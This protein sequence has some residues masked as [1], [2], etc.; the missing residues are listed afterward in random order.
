M[1]GDKAYSSRA[2]RAHLPRR[3]IKAVVPDKADQAANQTKKGEGRASGF[4]RRRVVQEAQRR[5]AVH[6]QDQGLEAAGHAFRHRPDSYM[7]ELELR[8]AFI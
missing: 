4:A 1:A 5:G 3:K 2:N 6:Q 7:A 8:G